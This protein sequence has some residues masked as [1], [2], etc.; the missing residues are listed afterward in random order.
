MGA[1]V[2]FT[3]MGT[4]RSCTGLKNSKWSFGIHDTCRIRDS[5]ISLSLSFFYDQSQSGW[6]FC[7]SASSK[8]SASMLI[9]SMR[10]KHASSP[11]RLFKLSVNCHCFSSMILSRKHVLVSLPSLYVL[12]T[13]FD[14]RRR[15]CIPCPR[16]RL[17][18]LETH[19]PFGGYPL[20]L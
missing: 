3:L 15:Q 9:K 5:A 8:F 12:L 1:L 13:C 18:P 14:F 6:A 20:K 19:Y 11:L 10:T 16:N 2:S 4:A 7:P 17:T